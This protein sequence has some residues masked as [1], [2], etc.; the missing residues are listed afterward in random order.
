MGMSGGGRVSESSEAV[1]YQWDRSNG[2]PEFYRGYFVPPTSADQV[3]L[4]LDEGV[5]GFLLSYGISG[6]AVRTAETTSRIPRVVAAASSCSLIKDAWVA[7]LMTRCR[8]L[9]EREARAS[10]EAAQPGAF[11]LPAVRT[12]SG[13][14]VKFLNAAACCTEEPA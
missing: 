6:L 10:C 9:V 3:P 2:Q 11:P 7:P 1:Q 13:I 4:S 5:T 14:L 12:T 8:L